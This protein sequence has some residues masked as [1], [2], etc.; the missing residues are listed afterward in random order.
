M[1]TKTILAVIA[2][3]I[4]ICSCTTN[5]DKRISDN[6]SGE[7]SDTVGVLYKAE[8]LRSFSSAS[9]KDSFSIVVTGKSIIDGQFRLQIITTVGESLLDETFPTNMLLDFG[10][11][12][13]PTDQDREDYIK[14]RID[15]F[16][17]EKQFRQPAIDT[18]DT[19]DEDY[20]KR[21]AWDEIASDPSAIG[22]HYLVGKEDGR[23]IAYS[24]KSGK[25]VLYFNC[26]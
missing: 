1:S 19:F 3:F 11:K 26:C 5:T 23:H 9:G 14:K 21:E 24:K 6:T 15:E 20:S 12:D 10:L 18:D 17:A 4:T 16:F 22:F 13:N 8:A 7:A 2:V 25:V